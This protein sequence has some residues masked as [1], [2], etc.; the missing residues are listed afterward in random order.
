MTIGFTHPERHP[1]MQ[2]YSAIRVSAGCGLT[3][4]ALCTAAQAQTSQSP[5]SEITPYKAVY[6]LEFAPAGK[7]SP[8]TGGTAS[9]TVEYTGSRCTEY[10]MI[11]TVKG[12]L[13]SDRGPIRLTSEA[14]FAENPAG[15][16]LAFA[17]IEHVNGQKSRQHNVMARRNAG[18]GVTVTSSQLPNGRIE[19]PRD[20]NLP[21]YGERLI[22]DAASGGR[23]SLTLKVY[24]PEVSL[25]SHEETALAFGPE[26]SNAL[27]KG[28]PADIDAL[29]NKPRKRVEIVARS[30]T[31]K[32]RMKEKLTRF[33]NSILTTSQVLDD[34]LQIKA[35]L[36]SL[37][38]LPQKPC[39]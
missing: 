39:S 20:V 13:N 29:R 36:A 24:N 28:H 9:L 1:I 23:K 12:T 4:L 21:L 8:F 34:Q 11:R 6:R 32:V 35:N 10:R 38:M 3:I 2:A 27:P 37:T 14:V 17:F 33:N 25:T 31:G 15:T 19:L 26:V 7:S 22:M 18:G 16:Q 30:A 5:A